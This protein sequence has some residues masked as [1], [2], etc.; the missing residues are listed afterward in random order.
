VCSPVYEDHLS[1][2]LDQGKKTS[3]KVSLF[4]TEKSALKDANWHL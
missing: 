3:L 1:E 4:A 2:N